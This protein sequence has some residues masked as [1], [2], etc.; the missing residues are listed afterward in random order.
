MRS[1][2]GTGLAL[3]LIASACT[4][5]SEPEPP[6]KPI[7]QADDRC[8]S[9][10]SA[11]FYAENAAYVDPD[12]P[13][14]PTG[15][16]PDFRLDEKALRAASAELA[17]TSGAMSFL[18]MSAGKLVWERYFN[19][20]RA[21]HANNVHSVAKSLLSLV[22]GRAIENDALSLD[23]TIQEHLPAALVPRDAPAIT[24]RDLL[25]MS[26][27]LEWEENVTEMNF[28]RDESFVR[29]ILEL[30][31]IDEPG[32]RFSY[33]TGLTQL[34]SAVIAEAT[35][36]STCEFAHKELFA[37]IGVTVD[38][39][40]TDPDGY[41]AG[42]HSMFM[43]PRELALVG[44]LVLDE[45]EGAVDKDG[46][47]AGSWLQ[48]SLAGTWK[49]GCR[50]PRQRVSYGYLWWRT[51]FYDV[52]AW[53][54]QGFGGQSMFIIPATQTVIVLTTDTHVQHT[55]VLEHGM[56]LANLIR[57]D[58]L[59]TPDGC[60]AFELYRADIDGGNI[61]R[62]TDHVAMDLWGAPSPDGGRIAFETTRDANWEI[63]TSDEDGDHVQR[64]T[65]R[66][67][68]D[69]FPDWSPDGRRVAFSRDGPDDE[70]I[71]TM[72]ADGKDVQRLTEGKDLTPSWSPDG[73]RIVFGRARGGDEPDDIHVIDADASPGEERLLRDLRG[74]APD[75][76]PDARHLTYSRDEAVYIAEVAGG[77]ER[78]V[79]DG[80]HPRWLP[81]GSLVFA[82]PDGAD[83]T[84]QIVRWL[85]GEIET[86]V[87]T[88]MDDLL[89]I[90]SADGAWL[91]YASAPKSARGGSGASR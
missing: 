18:V 54:A 88:A 64:L 40:L 4:G 31:Q 13:D 26:G 43:T 66:A 84:W 25:T 44:Q 10:E 51:D 24:V 33:N 8:A 87:D 74:G 19:G 61:R 35:G 91:T 39:W 80:R 14:I 81:D 30:D 5:S 65:A 75:W 76:S 23:D 57:P 11:G 63:Y 2:L 22:V 90:P 46:G 48:R 17:R 70:G 15:D 71:Y 79:A 68:A 47:P 53:T 12:I 9:E 29:Q 89:P 27:G 60:E 38:H 42:G 85:D 83:G 1:W 6:D 62:L 52:K 3:L 69:S 49:L 73:G 32:E 67:Q 7:Q 36:G 37:P 82:T 86:V 16:P 21:T 59:P 77:A 58:G 34:L 78:R 20:S 41:H 72:S 56:I 55:D 45:G 28:D 50:G